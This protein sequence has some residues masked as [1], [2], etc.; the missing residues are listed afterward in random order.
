MPR[1]VNATMLAALANDGFTMAHLIYLGVGSGLRVTDH[2]SDISYDSQTWDA[3]PYLLEVGTPSESRDLR[4]NQLGIQ[5]SGVGQA[6]QSVFLQNDW[7]N[8]PATVYLLI[9]DSNGGIT[10]A[11]L[12]I[13]NGQITNWQ[14]TESRKNSKVIVSISSH[15][16]D[17]QKTQGRLT[18]NNSQQFYFDGDVGFQYAAHTV[19]DIKWGRK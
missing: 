13:F 16:A 17:F 19:R 5:F 9:L 12:V 6:Y 18:N 15:W 8:K 7:M 14:F 11:P 1:T 3:S 10:G 4:V 2:A